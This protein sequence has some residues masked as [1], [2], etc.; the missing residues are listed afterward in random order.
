MRL[1][2]IFETQLAS[3]KNLTHWT[4]VLLL[5]LIVSGCVNFEVDKRCCN[6]EYE[7][8]TQNY[9]V[10]NEFHLYI[11]QAFTPNGD[12]RNEQ[13]Y[14]IGVG[15]ELEHLVIKKG[16]STVYESTN[17][18]DA[19]W[20]GGDERDGRYRYI[21]T[22]TSGTGDEFEAKGNVCVMRYGAAG[23]KHYDLETEKICDC[24]TM[25]MLDSIE[26][27]IYI[28]PECPSNDTL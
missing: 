10:P 28:S 25:D 6:G 14:P 16:I 9:T 1:S 15:W 22:F 23:G 8:P 5:I 11:P 18:L 17:R 13:F 26:G 2:S 27:A 24:T 21:M 19:F 4:G 7:I 3:M 12:G 20:D